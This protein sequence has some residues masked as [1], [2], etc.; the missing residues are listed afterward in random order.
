MLQ[1]T[2]RFFGSPRFHPNSKP[3][4]SF[5]G[6]SWWTTS[7]TPGNSTRG[8]NT[9]RRILSGPRL[10]TKSAGWSAPPCTSSAPASTPSTWPVR[11]LTFCHR[12]SA[13]AVRHRRRSPS[14]RVCT[15]L[16]RLSGLSSRTGSAVRWPTTTVSLVSSRSPALRLSWAARSTI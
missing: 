15:W 5:P 10:R 1:C 6:K 7:L 3:T 12:P 4:R 11:P 14:A 8:P 13:V 2:S 16:G 9:R